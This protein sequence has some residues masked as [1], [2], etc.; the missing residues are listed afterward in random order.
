MLPIQQSRSHFGDGRH[1][2]GVLAGLLRSNG[3]RHFVS[4]QIDSQ[5][6]LIF[7]LNVQAAGGQR[8]RTGIIK[9][10]VPLPHG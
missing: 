5:S 4:G 3:L 10:T 7:K 1:D 9:F 8:T 2:R 6:R